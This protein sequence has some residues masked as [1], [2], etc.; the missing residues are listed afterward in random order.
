MTTTIQPI[1]KS[2]YIAQPSKLSTDVLT[3]FRET[4]LP[5][6]TASFVDVSSGHHMYGDYIEYDSLEFTV[7]ARYVQDGAL[8]ISGGGY[9][10]KLTPELCL[11]SSIA[12]QGSSAP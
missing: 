7:D 9:Q 8:W 12:T 10:A 5:E 3:H 6:L 11:L 2:A 1:A 4:P